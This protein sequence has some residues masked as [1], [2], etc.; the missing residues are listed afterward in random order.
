M[1][2]RQ[3]QFI[4]PPPP[5]IADVFHQDRWN[6]VYLLQPDYGDKTEERVDPGI[7]NK[8]WHLM[9]FRKVGEDS[10]VSSHDK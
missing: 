8:L 3:V 6:Y 7:F 2:R 1:S 4:M 5:M 9:T 10:Y